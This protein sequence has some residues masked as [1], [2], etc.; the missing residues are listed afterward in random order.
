M[1]WPVSRFLKILHDTEVD[2]VTYRQLHT[3]RHPLH[4]WKIEN[5]QHFDERMGQIS[6][7]ACK[8][9]FAHRVILGAHDRFCVTRN[10]VVNVG[11]PDRGEGK[12]GDVRVVV[13]GDEEQTNH[14]RTRLRDTFV[15]CTHIHAQRE[16]GQRQS[17]GLRQVGSGMEVKQVKQRG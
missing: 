8:C 9:S 12:H 15:E 5:S 4:L 14:V 13:A 17:V 10:C 3:G 7:P 1:T 6:Q 16:R 11:C 2:T